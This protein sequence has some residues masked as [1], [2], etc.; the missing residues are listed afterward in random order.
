MAQQDVGRISLVTGVTHVHLGL[1]QVNVLAVDLGGELT[2]LH[3][4]LGHVHV[5]TGL[6]RHGAVE[7]LAGP[8]DDLIAADLV[9]A[10]TLFLAV[11]LRDGVGAVQ[12]V[13]Q[14][15]PPSIR[16]VQ[17]E[18]CIQCRDDKLGACGFCDFGVDVGGGDL[19]VAGLLNE[20]TN[21]LQECGVLVRILG[22]GV[23]GVPLIHLLLQV[24]TLCQQLAVA[25]SELLH[26]LA[27]AVPELL[28]LLLRALA[29]S[30]KYLV[31]NKVI[32]S[33]GDLKAARRDSF[34]LLGLGHDDSSFSDC[35]WSFYYSKI[36][37]RA[38]DRHP[39]GC[40]QH[41]H[42]PHPWGLPKICGHVSLFLLHKPHCG[43]LSYKPSQR[44]RS[45]GLVAS[46]EK[47]FTSGIFT[48]FTKMGY[49]PTHK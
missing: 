47:S 33:C 23:I 18:T 38:H 11:F 41:F 3:G 36:G 1:T 7:E 31:V 2:G 17:R 25:R 45:R 30:R 9:V 10:L 6:Q 29:D 44:R 37:D 22:A 20:V 32:Q 12:G 28:L 39:F 49:T 34:R 24:F 16:R 46:N 35:V 21:L 43:A 40:A 15:A 48:K 19:E 14:A 27:E 13:V 8:L 26:D 42:H 5:G 4:V